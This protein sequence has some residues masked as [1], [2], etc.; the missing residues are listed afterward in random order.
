[1]KKI[2]VG[3]LLVLFTSALNA[4][5]LILPAMTDGLTNGYFSIQCSYSYKSIPGSYSRY[6]NE[7]PVIN[8]GNYG[9]SGS[10]AEINT[11]VADKDSTDIHL[12]IR[13]ICR[14][15]ASIAYQFDDSRLKAIGDILLELP[16]HCA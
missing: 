8:Y 12:N 14:N 5:T 11:V 16:Q 13:L 3:S 10:L 9:L 7:G 2:A 6:S 15:N 1:M 4:A